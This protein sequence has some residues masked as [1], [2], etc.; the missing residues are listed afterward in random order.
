MKRHHYWRRYR[1]TALTTLSPT[2]NLYSP[3][4]RYCAAH[5][6]RD[7]RRD[8]NIL[9]SKR[10]PGGWLKGG[11]SPCAARC[12]RGD[13]QQVGGARSMPQDPYAKRSLPNSRNIHWAATE[14]CGFTRC[15][16]AVMASAH[17]RDRQPAGGSGA[18]DAPQPS[19]GASHPCTYR[20]DMM[21]S[22]IGRLSAPCC[23]PPTRVVVVGVVVVM[24]WTVRLWALPAVR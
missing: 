2:A 14:G 18:L 6:C 24:R 8:R 19:A 13:R 9:L 17:G 22:G 10:F 23:S 1:L 20:S 4:C 5:E 15:A 16:S 3:R 12:A 21:P 7:R 11:R